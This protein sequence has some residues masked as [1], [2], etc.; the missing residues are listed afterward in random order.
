MIILELKRTIKNIIIFYL[1][2]FFVF[3]TYAQVG[4]QSG[5]RHD[6][7]D[8]LRPI[9]PKH[10]FCQFHERF[11]PKKNDSKVLDKLVKIQNKNFINRKQKK[12]SSVFPLSQMDKEVRVNGQ[13]VSDDLRAPLLLEKFDEELSRT[14]NAHSWKEYQHLHKV[15]VANLK[16]TQE[17]SLRPETVKKF[18]VKLNS[19]EIHSNVK[20][21]LS[22][23]LKE[24]ILAVL[25]HQKR[26]QAQGHQNKGFYLQNSLLV[27]GA[28]LITTSL[29]LAL[30]GGAA[31]IS[32]PILLVGIIAATGAAGV[33]LIK[34]TVKSMGEAYAKKEKYGTSFACEQSVSFQKSWSKQ[35]TEAAV[36]F[37]AGIVVGGVIALLPTVASLVLA[38]LMAI[39]I[40]YMAY[41][42]FYL[43]YKNY[44]GEGGYQELMKKSDLVH[45]ER[46]Q[47]LIDHAN[48]KLGQVATDSTVGL[49]TLGLFVLVVYE[50]IVFTLK[51]QQKALKVE[52]EKML[53]YW[54]RIQDLSKTF[55]PGGNESGSRSAN[56]EAE[57]LSAVLAVEGESVSGLLT[58]DPNQG[59]ST[60]LQNFSGQGQGTE[61]FYS[62]LSYYFAK[63][64][65]LS[66]NDA[67]MIAHKMID[68]HLKAGNSKSKTSNT[69]ATDLTKQSEEMKFLVKLFG[70]EQNQVIKVFNNY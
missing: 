64:L 32:S 14:T 21:Q 52:K 60:L 69:N 68:K 63:L 33:P 45:G 9:Y 25:I 34:N 28:G 56:L 42:E 36:G 65:E 3:P 18:L 49:I 51:S 31:I 58:T 5:K 50:G 35:L 20:S 23:D 37:G 29:Y 24:V 67:A 40:G 2:C 6:S 10:S 43:A 66:S 55:K 38:P 30:A 22:A 59:F 19:Q 39:Y 4:T 41:K 16:N 57:E 12:G 1:C 54:A 8:N 53:Q 15:I 44:Y 46:K 48:K 13:K 27:L 62:E 70:L 7:F 11:V 26:V 47:I 17:N 61:I